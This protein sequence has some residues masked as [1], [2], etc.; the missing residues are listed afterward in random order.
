MVMHKIFAAGCAGLGPDPHLALM[1]AQHWFTI[2]L[3]LYQI[4]AIDKRQ[5]MDFCNLPTMHQW[6]ETNWSKWAPKQLFSNYS[7]AA[8][9]DV[10]KWKEVLNSINCPPAGLAICHKAPAVTSTPDTWADLPHSAKTGYIARYMFL[11]CLLQTC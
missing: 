6:M 4:S 3:W 2:P 8:P 9:G 11:S 7:S 1:V 5:L 10:E